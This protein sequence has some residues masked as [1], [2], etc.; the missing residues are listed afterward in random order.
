[1]IVINALASSVRL[2][3]A[4]AAELFTV[5]LKQK[6]L[7][8]TNNRKKRR[9]NQADKNLSNFNINL[10][11]SLTLPAQMLIVAKW[12]RPEKLPT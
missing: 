10:S 12:Q 9:K 2:K 7:M 3:L 8:K 6:I 4:T 1:M 5:K 11:A